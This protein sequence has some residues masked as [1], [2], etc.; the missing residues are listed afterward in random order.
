MVLSSSFP[1]SALTFLRF[2]VIAGHMWSIARIH[3]RVPIKVQLNMMLFAKTLLRKLL[4]SLTPSTY[5][6]PND[7]NAFSES[8]DEKKDEKQEGRKAQVMTLMTTDADRVSAFS[9]YL[10][11]SYVPLDTLTAVMNNRKTTEY[12]PQSRSS[13]SRFYCTQCLYVGSFSSMIYRLIIL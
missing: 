9:W 2:P 13:P 4:S 12:Q 1:L 7:N 5:S 11:T 10:F 8:P 6:A 3:V